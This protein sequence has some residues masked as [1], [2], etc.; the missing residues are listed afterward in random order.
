ML[1]RREFSKL[2]TT[3]AAGVA[4]SSTAKS[5]ARVI[6][7][8]ERVNFGVIGLNSRAYAH[9]SALTA[10]KANAAIT[11]VADV[12]SVILQKFAGETEKSMGAAPKADKDFRKLLESKDV[13]AITIATPDHWHTPI[14]IL[15]MQADKHVYVEKPCS[16][17]P[18]EVELLVAAQKKMGKQVQMGN[19]QRSSPHSIE[20]IDK[21]H[22]GLIGRAYY[23]KAW[24]CNTRKTMGT[25]KVVPVPATLDWDL[26]QGPAPRQQ[27]KDNVHPYNWHWLRIYGTGETLNNGTHEVD[28]CRWAL[29]TVWPQRITASGGRYHFK[30][31][32]QFYDTLVTSFE[33]DDKMISWENMSTNGMPLYNRDRGSAIHG[34][35]GTVILDRDGYEVHDLKGKLV[36]EYKIPKDKKTS[37]ADLVGRDSMTDLHFANLIDGIRTGAK[38]NSPIWDASTSVAILLM[39]NIA[40]ELHRE[41]KLDTK[42]GAF[43]DDAE[44]TK[45]RK[46]EYEKGWEPRI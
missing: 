21:I 22:N 4:V 42:T 37:S 15:G 8:N 9:L 26:W 44:A 13:D 6:G 20:I 12:D 18:H 33:Y 31:D 40:W 2:V 5:Y 1:T 43:V 3:A 32:W 28:V 29:Q 46:R 34:T 27:Y 16:H 7:A 41:L 38:L 11:H 24:Y 14:A 10:N 45:M 36:N 19:Q 35:E 17:N 39:S 25:G 30:D 23:A